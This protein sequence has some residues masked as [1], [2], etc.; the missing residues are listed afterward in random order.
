MTTSKY[1]KEN[2]SYKDTQLP[3]VVLWENVVNAPE[4]VKDLNYNDGVKLDS[5]DSDGNFINDVIN[6]RIDT[7]E[8]KIL[9]EWQFKD[10]GALAMKTDS[11][12]GLWLSPTGMLGK[13]GGVTTFAIDTS[14]NATFRGTITASTI[15]GSTITGGTVR[16]SSSGERVE[17]KSS[18][19]DMKIYDSSGNERMVLDSTGIDFKSSGGL[20][21]GGIRTTGSYFEI[22]PAKNGTVDI[23]LYPYT[24]SSYFHV[25]DS[26]G[27]PIL[28]VWNSTSGVR[29][30]AIGGLSDYAS[31]YVYGDMDMNHFD[32]SNVSD[33][34]VEDT[35][36]LGGVA[37]STWPTS[38]ANTSLSNLTTTSI[39]QDLVCSS[40]RSKSLG[41]STSKRWDRVY[42]YV[43]QL[44]G[45]GYVDDARAIYFERSRT[46]NPTVDGQVN[47]Y[48]ASGGGFRGNVNGW[49]GQFDMTAK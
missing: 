27:D 20:D 4:S 7:S 47:Y 34:E 13:S 28:S 12:N 29:Q 18:T 3:D 26:S 11:N 49:L 43:L 21:L 22:K 17:M 5:I 9:A 41:N 14:G 44:G 33:I 8:T 15:D 2:E 19:N 10:S 25:S 36:T 48:D 32:I 42:A 39:N 16:T 31:L 23:P 46:T 30:V 38:G 37:R 45:G 24:S 35:I 40:D 1:F 6:D